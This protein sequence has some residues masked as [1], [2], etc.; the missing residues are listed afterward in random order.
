LGDYQK[1]D[2]EQRAYEIHVKWNTC[3]AW[4]EVARNQHLFDVSHGIAE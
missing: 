1:I 4:R 2:C 3:V